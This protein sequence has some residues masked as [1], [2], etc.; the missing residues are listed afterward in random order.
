M[1][2]VISFIAVPVYLVA[3]PVLDLKS[4]SFGHPSAVKKNFHQQFRTNMSCADLDIF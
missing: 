4:D 3:P 2:S 1:G